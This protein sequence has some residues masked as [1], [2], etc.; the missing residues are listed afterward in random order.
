[1]NLVFQG[2]LTQA[3]QVRDNP[4]AARQAIRGGNSGL[5]ASPLALATVISVI[6]FVRQF[7]KESMNR[8]ARDLV[9]VSPS[10]ARRHDPLGDFRW[11]S[12]SGL[13]RRFAKD[14]HRIVLSRGIAEKFFVT[15]VQVQKQMLQCA[16]DP[17]I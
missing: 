10:L 4:G 8:N 1:M 11:H 15:T 9:G 3:R 6:G 2:D 16:F 5:P 13:D 7:P 17:K 12:K 14:C